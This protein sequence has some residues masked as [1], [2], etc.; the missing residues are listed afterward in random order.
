MRETGGG[1]GV[2]KIYT[3][4]MSLDDVAQRVNFMDAHGQG[5]WVGMRGGGEQIE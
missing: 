1:K 4:G 2:K 5:W 3:Y